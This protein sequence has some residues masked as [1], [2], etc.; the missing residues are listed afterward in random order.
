M[1]TTETLGHLG[2]LSRRLLTGCLTPAHD[3]TPLFTP[4][5]VAS[6][7]ALWVRDFAYMVEYAGEYIADQDIERAIIYIMKG[8]REDGWMP[9][10]IYADGTA[11]YAAGE[12]GSPVGQANLDNTPFLVYAVYH[13]LNRLN[14]E[15][16]ADLFLQ[17]EK[18]LSR[19]LDIIPLSRNGLVYNHPE[20]LHSPYG[21]TDTI[22]KTGELF[23]ESLL[24]WRSCKHMEELSSRYGSNEAAAKYRRLAESVEQNIGRLYDR[25]LGVFVAAGRNCRQAD[26]WGNAYLLYIG[27]PAAQYREQLLDY[28]QLNYQ[29]YAYKG[30]IRHLPQGEYWD[31]LL[32]EVP[33]EEYQNGAYWAT[34]SGWIIWC[35]AQR[36]GLT[37]ALATRDVIRSFSEDG[38]FECI[39]EGYSKL[40]SFVVSATNVY[41]AVKRLVEQ[42][43]NPAYIQAIEEVQN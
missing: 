15:A 8:Q 38:I 36:E 7:N 5:G 13:Y 6:Y 43:Q 24:F 41:G 20:D 16:A 30:Q 9:D 37:A 34:A 19:G 3:G 31:R 42:E 2:Q 27:F 33:H 29:N 22:G 40:D 10:R 21:F 32:I 23:M 12:A 1:N 17:W 14:T 25:E 4:D 11:V 39:N 35:L 26:I 28:L 18:P